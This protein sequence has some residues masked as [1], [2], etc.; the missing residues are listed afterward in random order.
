MGDLTVAKG[1]SFYYSAGN[2]IIETESGVLIAGCKKSV[3]PTDGS[4]TSIEEYAFARNRLGGSLVIPSGVTS[5][6]KYAFDECHL[7][8]VS[9]PNSVTSI[10]EHAFVGCDYLT[11]ITYHGTKAQWNAIGKGESWNARTGNYTIHCTDVD[12]SK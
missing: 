11:N 6:G 8:S 4:V 2:C 7:S 9:I 3:I 1:N 12:I 10:G 5:I